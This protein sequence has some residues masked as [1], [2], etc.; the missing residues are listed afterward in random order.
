MDMLWHNCEMDG[1]WSY[2][3]IKFQPLWYHAGQRKNAPSSCK[4]L[5]PEEIEMLW[6]PALI[7]KKKKDRKVVNA[8]E[9]IMVIKLVKLR[10]GGEANLPKPST[11]PRNYTFLDDINANQWMC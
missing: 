4:Y 1:N 6:L 5:P 8:F 7:K 11:S 9:M 3:K 2:R 10:I